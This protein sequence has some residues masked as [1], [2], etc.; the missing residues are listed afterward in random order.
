VGVG[1]ARGEP[2][3]PERLILASASPQRRAILAQVGLPFTVQP[4]GVEEL[5]SG[6][7]AAVAA[8]NARRKALAVPGELVL[9]ADTLV[10]VDGEILGK[11]RDAAQAVEYVA[12]LA[13]RAHEVV[14]GIALAR[15]GEVMAEA[16]DITEVIFRALTAEEVEAYVGLGEWDGRA[17][18]YAIQGAGA[19]LV[20]S[21]TGDYLNV[22]GLPLARLLDVLPHSSL[23]QILTR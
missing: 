16:V 7:P 20:R 12:R 19:A 21:I 4:A 17:G 11:P 10:T 14:G 3:L 9:G 8:E 5:T 15:E 6:E 1:R 2:V 18:G 23:Q 22:V 13:G